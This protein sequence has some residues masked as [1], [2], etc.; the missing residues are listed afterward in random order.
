MP[1]VRPLSAL[2]QSI[3]EMADAAQKANIT[4]VRRATER[5][6]DDVDRRGSRYTIRGRGG[7]PVPL[8]A[9]ADTKTFG[10]INTPVGRVRG[11]PEGFW[12]IVQ[13]GS[14]AHVITT[15]RKKAG[16]RQSVRTT[17]RRLDTGKQT[18]GLSPVRTPYGPRQYVRHPGHRTIAR[19]WDASMAVAPE[20]VGEALA[21]EQTKA[22][23]A[24]FLGR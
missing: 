2:R 18:S 16:G 12:H 1:T 20:I 22:M 6:R 5:L 14:G 11:V 3:F 9:T 7:R 10:D 13:Y 8:G 17:V 4:A 15:G 21:Y 19:P 24:A 23:T